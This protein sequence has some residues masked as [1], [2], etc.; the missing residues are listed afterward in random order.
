MEVDDSSMKF[1]PADKNM[2]K[3]IKASEDL[4]KMEV[5]ISNGFMW[6]SYRCIVVHKRHGIMTACLYAD[7]DKE[8]VWWWTQRHGTIIPLEDVLCWMPLKMLPAI[9]EEWWIE[10]EEKEDIARGS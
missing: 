5:S 7:D 2:M 8:N 10:L 3:W 4:P 6:E 9:P 1:I